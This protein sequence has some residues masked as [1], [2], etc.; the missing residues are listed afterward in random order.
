MIWERIHAW[1]AAFTTSK[2]TALLE[3]E[4]EWLKDSLEAL[5]AENA[6]LRKN[7]EALINTALCEAGKPALPEANLPKAKVEIIRKLTS[8]Q[9]QRRYV[10]EQTRTGMAL[11]KHFV[12]NAEKKI[13]G[14]K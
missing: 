6:G 8:H 7:N 2:R 9:Q 10:I 4:N 1:W 3:Y 12:A 13:A 14:E 5:L 11:A